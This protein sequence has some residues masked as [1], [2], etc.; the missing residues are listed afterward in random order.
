MYSSSTSSSES[1]FGFVFMVGALSASIL[2]VLL[3]LVPEFVQIYAKAGLPVS[4]LTAAFVVHRS[5]AAIWFVLVGCLLSLL[6][7]T[8]V[9]RRTPKTVASSVLVLYV[10]LFGTLAMSLC[11]P[12]FALAHQ[13]G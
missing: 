11:M 10:M 4:F 5:T 8:S 9:Y 12:L 13:L 6:P 7:L 3:V 2:T 1:P